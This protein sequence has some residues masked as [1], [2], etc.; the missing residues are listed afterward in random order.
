MADL[1]QF[2]GQRLDDGAVRMGRST[3]WNITVPTNVVL[4]TFSD[5]LHLIH[6]VFDIFHSQRCFPLTMR[7]PLLILKGTVHPKTKNMFV[8]L[9]YLLYS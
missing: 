1:D 5:K 4:L 6:H 7:Q 9:L 8:H 3:L 2:L